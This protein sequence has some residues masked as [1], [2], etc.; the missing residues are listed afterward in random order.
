MVWSDPRFSWDGALAEDLW[1]CYKSID[2]YDEIP[3]EFKP[4]SIS[5]E[6]RFS[7]ETIPSENPFGLH[8]FW[9]WLQPH[10]PEVRTSLENCPEALGIFPPELLDSHSG[11]HDL[12]CS[13][14]NAWGSFDQRT[15]ITFNYK[16]HCGP[17][18]STQSN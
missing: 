9:P 1:F 6:M 2:I 3:D 5:D 17:N 10:A 15:N 14:D 16:A 18:V 8:K 11:W 7:S 4:A 12:I 13:L